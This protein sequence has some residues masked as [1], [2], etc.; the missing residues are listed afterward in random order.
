MF[1]VKESKLERDRNKKRKE[2]SRNE[3][4]KG[5]SLSPKSTADWLGKWKLTV[6]GRQFKTDEEGI[7]G[8]LKGS[9][10]SELDVG[11]E[12]GREIDIELLR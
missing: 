9:G 1:C 12:S 5:A 7:L 10:V 3:L 11:M 6:K 2:P 8:V 4:M